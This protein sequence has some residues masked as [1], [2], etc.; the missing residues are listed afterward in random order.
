MRE[1]GHTCPQEQSHEQPPRVGASVNIYLSSFQ[2]V[3]YEVAK[4]VKIDKIS[5]ISTIEKFAEGA[6]IKVPIQ[7]FG[8]S[9]ST[10]T[11]VV[12]LSA[13]FVHK[14]H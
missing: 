7:Q 10:S 3:S 11:P 6:E 4:F 8:T 13:N 2:T 1:P 9:R 5:K 12:L 14:C